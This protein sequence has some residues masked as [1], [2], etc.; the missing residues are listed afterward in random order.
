MSKTTPNSEYTKYMVIAHY[1]G[2]STKIINCV[3]FIHY[4]FPHIAMGENVY[5]HNNNIESFNDYYTSLIIL[6]IKEDINRL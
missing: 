2:I 3:K 5:L 1:Q 6:Y 4:M